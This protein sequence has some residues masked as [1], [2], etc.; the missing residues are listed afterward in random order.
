M[1]GKQREPDRWIHTT[2]MGLTEG[3]GDK[4]GWLG[5]VGADR[6][7]RGRGG[8]FFFIFYFVWNGLWREGLRCDVRR[9]RHEEMMGGKGGVVG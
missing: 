9:E 4:K 7:G 8:V 5:W 3:E 6:V 1:V 2:G